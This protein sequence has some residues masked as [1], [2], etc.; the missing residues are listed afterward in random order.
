MSNGDI[1]KQL[2]LEK[3]LLVIKKLESEKNIKNDAIAIIGMSCRFP[4]ANN[5]GEFW[6]LLRT[7]ANAITE[8]PADR[9]SND[10]Y[11]DKA[12]KPG[13]IVTSKGGF[14]RG[15]KDFDAAFFNISPREAEYID[16]QQRILLEEIWKALENAYILPLALENTNAGVFI[17]I[18]SIDYIDVLSGN[19]KENQINAYISTGNS[20]SAT[21][22]RVSYFLGLNGPNMAI[23]TACSSS[24][25]ALHE[26]CNGLNNGDCSL[27][28][29]GGVN[30]LL[31]PKVSISLSS[32]GMLSPDG[33]CKT[34]D[35][36]ADGYVRS[37]G[38]GIVILKRLSDALIDNDRILAVIKA[39]HCNHNGSTSGFTVP[40]GK[41]QKELFAQN[42]KSANIKPDNIEYIECHGTATGLGDPIE[43][44]SIS[45]FYIENKAKSG[46]IK[47]GAVKSNIGHLEAASG[48]A[49]V[50]KTILCINHNLIP[51]NLHLKNLNANI[52]NSEQLDFLTESCPIDFKQEGKYA[53]INSFGFSG[54]NA[55]IIIGSAPVLKKSIISNEDSA[56]SSRQNNLYV[57]PL[58]AKTDKSLKKMAE[59]LS[60]YIKNN[61]SISLSEI[62]FS[63]MTT[64]ESFAY[65]FACVVDS[66][67]LLCQHLDS[68]VNNITMENKDY[69][70]NNIHDAS[71]DASLLAKLHQVAL[72]NCMN[73]EN[74]PANVL[75]AHED[76]II[77]AE[78]YVKGFALDWS[79]LTNNEQAK[80]I[81]MPSYAFDGQKYWVKK[82]AENTN[83]PNQYD[84]IKQNDITTEEEIAE[85]LL[86]LLSK[87]TKNS[88]S[89]INVDSDLTLLGIDSIMIKEMA[90]EIE[91]KFGFQDI[92]MFYNANTIK[93]IATCIV[94]QRRPIEES[95]ELHYT[96]SLI[97]HENK[98]INPQKRKKIADGDVAIIGMS[99]R[100][101]MANSL[102]ELYVNLSESKN[103]IQKV[104]RDRWHGE[105]QY[106]AGFINN[107]NLFDYRKFNISLLEAML[108]QPE[109]RLLLEETWHCCESAGYDPLQW[110]DRDSPNDVGVFI[111]ASC[112]DYL[113]VVKEY[114]DQKQ[115]SLPY[116][117]QIYTFANRLSY[118]YNFT[119]PSMTLDTACSSS[120]F[121]LYNAYYSV[122]NNE[123]K[124]AFVGGV[125]LILH[126]SRFASLDAVGFLAKDY[127]CRSFCEGGTGYVPG[128][129]VSVLMLKKYDQAIKDK[130]NILAIIKGIKVNNDGKTKGFTVPN[131]KAQLHLIENTLKTTQ[132]NPESISFIECHGT[133]TQLGDPIEIE[134]LTKVFNQYTSKKSFIPI[135]SIK[136]NFG[137]LEAA[138]GLAQ[139]AKVVLQLQSRSLFPN[140]MHG[141]ELNKNIHFEQTPFYVQNKLESISQDPSKALIASISSF[142]A[143]G[144]N[145]HAILEEYIQPNQSY[146]DKS[147]Y[148]II[149]SAD[150][151]YSLHAS[152]AD[153]Y[154]FLSSSEH[155][156]FSCQYN[157]ANIAGTLL[158]GRRQGSYRIAFVC[159]NDLTNLLNS[160]VTCLS[161]VD[162]KNIE[163]VFYEE[164]VKSNDKANLLNDSQY[165]SK[166]ELEQIALKWVEGYEIR[167]LFNHMIFNKVYLPGMA[168]EQSLISLSAITTPSISAS[169]DVDD[170]TV[171][172]QVRVIFKQIIQEI[173]DKFTDDDDFMT[174]G[175]DSIVG[176]RIHEKLCSQ[177]GDLDPLALVEHNTFN[178]ITNFIKK[179]QQSNQ[180]K[181]S[182][183][184]Y[185]KDSN[186]IETIHT[187]ID[188]KLVDRINLL[189]FAEI[190]KSYKQYGDPQID[191][192][193][194]LI[195]IAPKHKIEICVSGE[196]APVFLLAPFNSNCSIWI[197]QILYLSKRF[198]V[199]AIHYPGIGNSDWIASMTS[200]SDLGNIIIKVIM[201]LYE[202]QIINSKLVSLVGWS[203]GGYL[204]QTIAIE[205]PQHVKNLILISTT[206]ITWSSKEYKITGEKFAQKA[207]EEFN[208]N[209]AKLPNFI[210][211]M[212]YFIPLL[213]IHHIE[214]F[215]LG[216]RNK[217][218]INKYL[219]MIAR[220]KNKKVASLL[221]CRV[222]LISGKLDELM[223]I[224]FA[225][226]LHEMIK[227]SIFFE[228]A[229]GKH[230]MTLFNST[231]INKKLISWL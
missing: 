220:F 109:E 114:N 228:V 208:E 122:I 92:S 80:R 19:L 183:P 217:E 93:D 155:K 18:S 200:F 143:G 141:S 132:I 222:C 189:N 168:F 74:I 204:A 131:P 229:S 51:K 192:K 11:Y 70:Y 28:I 108:I 40:C 130:D 20:H 4:G 149:L 62:S 144:S 86:N 9:W 221:K 124:I 49:G 225:K 180:P 153:L 65:R 31:T 63:L 76:I 96:S 151:K 170:M 164:Q 177:F 172:D 22:G 105:Q 118:F 193:L 169:L 112:H 25:V 179:E 95:S 123:S 181:T 111:G 223:P 186:E 194:M 47:L 157:V 207:A 44:N 121:A 117:S 165:I 102:N 224:N 116:S 162:F 59:Q 166:F 73:Q 7:G 26:A 120:L 133:G 8:V 17:G 142:G 174:L 75:P 119:G 90:V 2:L 88:R 54:T 23:D 71:K 146:G 219:L 97:S 91:N 231:I 37:E 77:L 199:I 148:L 205:H 203:F 67:E 53:A 156:V 161:S 188:D 176:S 230:F 33:Y 147:H 27:A 197:N 57:I 104:P 15:I 202:S 195:D 140:V 201:S 85:Y 126:P 173:P 115:T 30:A 46:K 135:S 163:G 103:S 206:T 38:C 3:A 39:S 82:S 136:S 209:F 127:R 69:F 78:L 83:L 58:S 190:I 56:P 216:T 81:D 218:V 129:G 5:P 152:I 48:I 16:P 171:K 6:E 211:D 198:K 175:I 64:R 36:D 41:I 214:A 99:G 24:L 125:N 60:D 145:A 68:F 160:L 158:F 154:H 42:I 32:A 227:G 100:F 150:S 34:F 187:L 191:L 107:V 178:L 113:E 167:H 66:K 134:A 226:E 137:H 128:E 212:P 29:T 72:N 12:G 98:E 110:V 61:L 35:D 55:Q 101:P 1:N 138:A 14:I 213:S 94:T 79:I 10:F 50:I 52:N 106:Q 185:L 184:Q 89:T 13:K 87:T 210:K 196:G 21:V 43:V 84:G 182:V 159:E 215:V 45:E 139:I